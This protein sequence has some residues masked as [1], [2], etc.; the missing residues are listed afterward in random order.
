MRKKG[1]DCKCEKTAIKKGRGKGRNKKKRLEV[2]NEA[3]WAKLWI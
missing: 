3:I 2:R 1:I